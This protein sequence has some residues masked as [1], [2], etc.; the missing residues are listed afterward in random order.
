MSEN[1]AF[2]LCLSYDFKHRDKS[3]SCLTFVTSFNR[4][5]Y[6]IVL[7]PAQDGSSEEI[8]FKQQTN[9]NCRSSMLDGIT[10]SQMSGRGSPQIFQ[11]CYKC[12]KLQTLMD[13]QLITTSTKD[14]Q[15]EMN[16]VYLVT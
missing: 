12:Y 1:F 6:S 14:L 13:R 15:K 9:T 7:A 3:G 10:R 11:E 16:F 8:Q 5:I 4:I 2:L